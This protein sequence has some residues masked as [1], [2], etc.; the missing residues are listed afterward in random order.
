M[1][2]ANLAQDVRYAARTFRRSQGFT[3]VAVL[4]LAL[5]IGATTAVV[6]LANAVLLRPLPFDEPDRLVVIWSD[7]SPVGGDTRSQT[8]LPNYLAWKERASSIED[9]AALLPV[10]Y[11]LT[12]NG[13]PTRLEGGRVTTNLFSLLG[14]RAI[15]GRTFAI[16]DEGPQAS[17]VAV[18]T[19]SLWISQFGADSEIVGRSIQLNGLSHTVIG[20]V[21]SDF[22]FPNPDV[23]VWVP[24]AFSAEELA[25]PMAFSHYVVARLEGGAV[26][27]EAQVEM[28]AITTSLQEQAGGP[29][30]GLGAT[31]AP[32]HLEL[33]RDAG[34]TLIILLAAVGAVLLVACA[35][36]ANLLLA[37][38]SVRRKE[39]AL[40]KALGA[41]G[42][43][44]L[45]QLLTESALL[46]CLGVIL[47]IALA[48]HSFEYLARLMPGTYPEGTA[49]MLDWRVL[50]FTAGIA[51]LTV[52][53]FGTG[54]ALAAS[55]LKLST[56]LTRGGGAP[57]TA[58]G[59]R[60][61][62]L[63][64]IGEIAITASLLVSAGLLL[65]SY[66]EVSNVDPGF[67]AG[68]LLIAETELSPAQYGEPGS[69]RAFSERVLER[70]NALPGVTG[71]GYASIAPLRGASRSLMI[72]DGRE[73]APIEEAAQFVISD[74]VV[75]P[76]YLSTLG[77]PLVQGRHLDARDSVDGPLSVVINQALARLHWPDEDPVGA[78]IRLG[79]PTNPAHTVVGIV[80]DIRQAGLDVR[81]EPEMYFTF[82]QRID[83]APG[84]LGVAPR[85]LLVRTQGDPLALAASVRDAVWAVDPNQPVS[86]IGTMS[87]VL[88]AEL[89]DRGTQLTL[90]GGFAVAALLL[91]SVGLYGV[92]SY[93]ITQR[94]SEIGLRMALG[95]RRRIVVCAVPKNGLSLTA[96]G[97]LFGLVAALG[98]SRLLASF[99]FNVEPADPAIFL[100][101]AALLLVVAVVASCLPAGRAASVEPISALRVE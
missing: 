26:L 60:M 29:N 8:T 79:L 55:R 58:R 51:V 2:L 3:V 56:A 64:V 32:L 99:L 92:L 49:P 89:V 78:R 42:G 1:T 101:V 57:G 66:A 13:E 34:P 61:R 38:S 27:S 62:D 9:I 31:V 36:V 16:D 41:T 83:D 52:L 40:R 85:Y 82:A 68:N 15:L 74:R 96:V 88:D 53:L 70:V 65:R 72:I 12:G 48:T 7:I 93:T 67:R 22:R 21:P 28:T 25:Q 50:S 6:S 11:N 59:S 39:L 76:G 10:T 44:V 77:V 45:G 98:F 18:I 5:G 43:R 86:T 47:G 97:I 37:R 91:A 95:A 14:L 63:V 24:A 94:T 80:G 4:I 20:V 90:I 23:A 30:L 100:G 81:P 87:D 69:S 84:P 54:P 71:A 17:P 46:A 75:S 33:S 35:N 73:P 19:E